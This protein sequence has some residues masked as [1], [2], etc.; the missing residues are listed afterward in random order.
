M[1]TVIPVLSLCVGRGLSCFHK[2]LEEVVFLPH[3]TEGQLG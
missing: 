1:L 3:T 2:L